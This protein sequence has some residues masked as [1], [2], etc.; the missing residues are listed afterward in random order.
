MNTNTGIWIG[1]GVL[2]ALVIASI[3]NGTSPQPVTQPNDKPKVE[4]KKVIL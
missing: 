1:L 2:G 3:S 4:P